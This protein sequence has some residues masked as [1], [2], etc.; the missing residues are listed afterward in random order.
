[1][2]NG[3]SLLAHVVESQDLLGPEEVLLLPLLP[4]VFGDQ[5]SETG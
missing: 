4:P 2:P 3:K 1:M 5:F